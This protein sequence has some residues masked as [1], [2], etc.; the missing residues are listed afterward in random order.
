LRNSSR[1]NVYVL[2]FLP[3]YSDNKFCVAKFMR[4]VPLS[5]LAVQ[6]VKGVG[7][8]RA[9]QLAHLGI[10][11]VEDLVFSVPRRYEDRSRLLPIRQLALG[12]LATVRGRVLAK[13][14][15]RA[16]GGQAIVEA[17]LGDAT[18]V[19]FCRW[20]NQPYLAKWLRVGEEL[21]VYGRV[22][23][24]LPGS[25]R[26]AGSHLQLIH[27][28]IERVDGDADEA[29][30]HMGRIVPV[31]SLTGG[32]NQRW[33]RR[34][35]R[36]AL[37]RHAALIRE[38]LPS[39]IRDRHHLQPLAWALEQIHFPESWD[40]LEHARRRLAFE[41]L[42]VM[43]VALARRRARLTSR[44]KPRQYIREGPL[45]T[46][47]LDRLAFSLTASQRQVLDELVADLCKPTPMLRLLQGDVGCGKTVVAASLMAVV[48]QSGYQVALM[49]PTELLAEQHH[50]VFRGYL[51]PLGVRVG[52]VSQGVS[53][54]ERKRLIRELADDSIKIV[55]GT[56]ALIEP[57][58]SFANL[59]L[60]V[61]DEQHKFGVVQRNALARKAQLPDVL[62]MTATPIPRTLALSIYGDLACSTITELP[63]G[64]VPVRTLIL[65]ES[66]RPDAY[67]LIREELR[68]GRQGYVVYPLVEA[69]DDRE[70][71]AATQMAEYLKTRIF[72]KSAVELLHGQMR[73]KEKETIMQAFAEGRI[74]LLVST[75]IVEV[76]LD[77]PNATVM[78]IEHP[79]HFGL[80]QLHQMRGR[81]G[82][83]AQPAT[84][85]VIGD[86]ADEAAQQRLSAFAGTTDGFRLAESDLELRGPGE[87]LGR[88]Q[89]GLLRFRIANL[90]RDRELLEAARKEAFELVGKD[91]QMA[92]PE[93]TALKQRLRI[94]SS[95][96][97]P[98][99]GLFRRNS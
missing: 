80:A 73:P 2:P 62:V 82:R 99:V 35:V 43:H 20:F 83:G 39:S 14:L 42:F 88:R 70:V 38:T 7:P 31:Y 12:Q 86:A 77:V 19:I 60:V 29:S 55:V 81:I 4:Q 13:G 67:R 26:Q 95:R 34:I 30:L 58:V 68:Q 23:P 17:A 74:Q 91:P 8:A 61:I 46:A 63:P 21:I 11:T 56:H 18:G 37:S 69:K 50:R 1:G 92:S 45:I 57:A 84:C 49:A 79:E 94:S 10:Q 64:R 40:A 52:L 54:Q 16:R 66:Q 33:F 78:L 65:P 72:P 24:D 53:V 96:S 22:E 75:V 41:E 90:I 97:S 44:E 28:E 76:G 47:F 6:Y 51:E 93:L 25:R 48:I 98:S 27:P 3:L 9:A 89:S 5:E 71:K 59:A 87:L 32:L 36:H 85:L 15:R